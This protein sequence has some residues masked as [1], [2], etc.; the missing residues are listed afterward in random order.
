MSKSPDGLNH[1]GA[2]VALY[3]PATLEYIRGKQTASHSFGIYAALSE[4]GKF[5]NMDL[6]DN[7][8]R[9]IR[10]E[11]DGKSQIIYSFKTAHGDRAKSPAGVTYDLYEEISTDSQ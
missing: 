10:F 3:D 6:G 5:I 4:S 1:Q 2:F 8:P 9:G 11:L 7:Y